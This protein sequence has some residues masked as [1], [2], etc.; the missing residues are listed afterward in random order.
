[1]SLLTTKEKQDNNKVIFCIFVVHSG[2]CL[3]GLITQIDAGQYHKLIHQATKCMRR[4]ECTRL[5]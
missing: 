1:M 5:V 4:D 3:N 2:I